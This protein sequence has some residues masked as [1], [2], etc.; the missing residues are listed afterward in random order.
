MALVSIH[1]GL[2]GF[3]DLETNSK[4]WFQSVRGVYM[5]GC[6]IALAVDLSNAET[7]MIIKK[8]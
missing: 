4:T 2:E 6:P 3:L 7:I 5:Q 1:A 8:F